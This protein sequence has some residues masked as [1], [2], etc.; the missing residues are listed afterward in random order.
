MGT[1][2]T[3]SLCDIIDDNGN[4][5]LAWPKEYGSMRGGSQGNNSTNTN[6]NTNT[7]NNTNTN[8]NTNTN[9]AMKINEDSYL[10]FFHSS[11]DPPE[12]GD[13]LKTYYKI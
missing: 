2:K 9:K 11:R 10:L 8:T 5:Y 7:T 13:V 6:T 12:T 4:V 3:K 1:G